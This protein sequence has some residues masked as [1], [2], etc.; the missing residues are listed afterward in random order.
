[1]MQAVMIIRAPTDAALMMIIVVIFGWV[2][3]GKSGD[4]DDDSRVGDE[5]D[6]DEGVGIRVVSSKMKR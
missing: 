1:M 2:G 4:D 5:V 6:T 3:S